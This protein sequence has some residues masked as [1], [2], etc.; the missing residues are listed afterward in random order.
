MAM[1]NARGGCLSCASSH[2][3]KNSNYRP[4]FDNQERKQR[5]AGEIIRKNREATAIV[6]IGTVVKYGLLAIMHCLFGFNLMIYCQT[7]HNSAVQHIIRANFVVALMLL[8]DHIAQHF[9]RTGWQSPVVKIIVC[10]IEACGMAYVA[11]VFW[12]TVQTA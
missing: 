10:I 7:S 9:T 5:V 11:Y 4:S 3:L 2:R 12:L 1:Q 6:P 8:W